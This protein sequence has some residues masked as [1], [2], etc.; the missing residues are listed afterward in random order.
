[1]IVE[2]QTDA[3]RLNEIANHPSVYPWVHGSIV[4]E[5]DL[6][7]VVSRPGN[8]V[9]LGEHGGIVFHAMQLGLFEAH[10][11][12]LPE[13][14]GAWTERAVWD[15]LHW[16]FTRSNAVE[17]LTRIPKGNYAARAL[18]KQIKGE[19]AWRAERGWVMDHEII[20][21]DIFSM[22]LQHWLT[23]APGLEKAGEWFHGRLEEEFERL[24]HTEPQHE[25][26]ATHDRYVGATVEMIRG[27]QIDKAIITYNRWA[28]VSGYN[29]VSVVSTSPLTLNI[30]NALVMPR[31]E[32]IHVPTMVGEG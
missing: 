2:R 16:M 1:M 27:G 22:T 8:I 4:G 10:T 12:V 26:D 11:L 31:G 13:G 7:D 29:P 15:C 6:S 14:R 30:G 5:L 21:A 28:A 18:V 20:P 32:D 3:K 25:D 19:F 17:I 9:L 23:V 24:G